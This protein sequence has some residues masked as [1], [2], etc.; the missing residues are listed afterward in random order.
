MLYAIRWTWLQR[1]PKPPIVYSETIQI[2]M[3][4]IKRQNKETLIGAIYKEFL[5]L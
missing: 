1:V 3:E 2:R 5:F 4:S